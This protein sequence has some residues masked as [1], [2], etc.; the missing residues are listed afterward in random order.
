MHLDSYECKNEQLL[1]ANADY[2]SQASEGHTANIRALERWWNLPAGSLKNFRANK[3]RR[4]NG[5]VELVL[6]R[7]PEKV[8]LYINT[9]VTPAQRERIRKILET[10]I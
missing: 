5:Q 9:M 10:V 6:D 2:E 1:L 7:N 3:N 8:R 4:T